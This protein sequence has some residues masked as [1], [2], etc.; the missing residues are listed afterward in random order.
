M[1]KVNL[2]LVELLIVLIFCFVIFFVSVLGAYYAHGVYENS[3]KQCEKYQNGT[4]R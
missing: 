3:I 1:R 2:A 4:D